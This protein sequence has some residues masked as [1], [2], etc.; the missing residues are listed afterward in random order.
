MWILITRDLIDFYGP[1]VNEQAGHNYAKDFG[2]NRYQMRE[3]RDSK[4]CLTYEGKPTET[5]RE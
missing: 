4:V 5:D 2:I 3:L 1:F